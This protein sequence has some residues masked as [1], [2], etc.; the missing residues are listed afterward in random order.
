MGMVAFRYFA[1]AH[2]IALSGI[3]GRSTLDLHQH[4]VEQVT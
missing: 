2:K 1:K 3:S 4:D